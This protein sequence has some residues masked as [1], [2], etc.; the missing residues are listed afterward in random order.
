MLRTAFKSGRDFRRLTAIVQQYGL[1]CN[2]YE[3]HSNLHATSNLC[4]R[5][6]TTTGG[7]SLS[8]DD[9]VMINQ[10][11]YGFHVFKLIYW[12]FDMKVPG[13]LTPLRSVSAC[14]TFTRQPQEERSHTPQ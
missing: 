4:L 2:D 7:F 5:N 13:V 8:Q 12:M 14:D 1:N 3:K 6:P 10:A 11:S 9:D